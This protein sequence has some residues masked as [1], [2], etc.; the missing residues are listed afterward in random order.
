MLTVY[1]TRGMG[2]EAKGKVDCYLFHQL[3]LINN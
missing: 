2:M 3:A 1:F